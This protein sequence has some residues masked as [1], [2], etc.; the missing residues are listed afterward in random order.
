MTCTDYATE[1]QYQAFLN[2]DGSMVH[3]ANTETPQKQIASLGKNAP[4]VKL[5]IKIKKRK[6]SKKIF[7]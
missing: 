1:N 7:W 5:P 2:P 3:N 4:V 6:S